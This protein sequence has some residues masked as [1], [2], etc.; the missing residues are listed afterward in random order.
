VDRI[1]DPGTLDDYELRGVAFAGAVSVP[2]AVGRA[3]GGYLS[4]RSDKARAYQGSWTNI[5]DPATLETTPP[6]TT[7]D[8]VAYYANSATILLSATDEG[9]GVA[10]TYYILDGGSQVESS[11]VVVTHA[12]THSLE[13]WSVDVTGN[14]EA[15]HTVTF[16]VVV[17]PSSNGTPSTPST[18][19]SVKHGRPFTAFGYIIRHTAGTS[20][21]T[22]LYYRWQKS[23]G[24]YRWVLRKTVTAKVLNVLDFSKYWDSTSMPY[25][26]KW[27][28]RARHKVGSVYKYSGYRTFT[29]S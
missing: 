19:S 11:T 15:H 7:S 2:V 17:P 9:S 4:S 20:P 22:L 14:V 1:V 26:G 23:S 25:A 13:F 29:A 12:G 16:T 27:R 28:V 18:P 5:P 24:K 8:R 6:V 3:Y 10:H 21:V